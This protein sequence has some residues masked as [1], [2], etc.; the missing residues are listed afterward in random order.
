MQ[1]GPV[2]EGVGFKS[3]SK[4]IPLIERRLELKR[5]VRAASDGRR[6]ACHGL[7]VLH[8][9]RLEVCLIDIR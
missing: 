3:G 1:L 5:K 9:C 7:R 8:A 2:H 4:R 6:A